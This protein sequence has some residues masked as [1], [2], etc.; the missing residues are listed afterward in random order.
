MTSTQFHLM[1]RKSKTSAIRVETHEFHGQDFNTVRE[2]LATKIEEIEISDP[3]LFVRK[4]YV[5]GVDGKAQAT[6]DRELQYDWV[7]AIYAV[8]ERWIL[9]PV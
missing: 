4:V 9:E 6:L 3:T 5:F 1:D 8:S 2:E 7:E